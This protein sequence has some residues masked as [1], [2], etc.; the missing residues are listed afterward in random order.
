MHGGDGPPAG[1]AGGT[2]M[3]VRAAA[4]LAEALDGTDYALS[5]IG[6]SGGEITPDVYSSYYH[7]AD[8]RICARF[9]IQ[10]VVGDTCG[11]AGM[12]T[13]LRAIP[14]YLQIC[15]EM[16]R[17]CP[18]VILL[19]HSNPMAPLLPG[20]AQILRHQRIGI[21]TRVQGGIR[22][23]GELLGIPPR[24]LSCTWIGTNHYYWFTSV[25]HHAE[26]VYPRLKAAMAER[27][28][29]ASPQQMTHQLSCIY[30]HCFVY[31]QD[32]HIVEFYPFLTQAASFDEL[33]YQLA[34]EG[35]HVHDGAH[36]TE[37]PTPGRASA[38]DRRAFFANYQAILDEDE[39]ARRRWRA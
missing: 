27:C 32:D 39:A 21:C 20:T 16:E 6:G 8:V 17:R 36:Q 37:L 19:N 4:T 29:T 7:A 35:H 30:E 9:G 13:G 25:R 22:H 33:P 14:A 1:R 31:P 23:A 12:M 26:D 38:D 24:E 28:A 5:S 2:G 34:S 18:K 15:R 3:T 11:P 10:Q